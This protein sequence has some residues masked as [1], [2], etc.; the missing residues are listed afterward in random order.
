[1]DLKKTIVL[2][3]LVAAS[4][5][6]ASIAHAHDTAAETESTGPNRTMLRSGVVILGLSYV[7]AFVVAVTNSRSDDDYLFIPVAGPWLDLAHRDCPPGPC[8]HE[9]LNKALLITDGVFQ[10]IGALDSPRPREQW[11]RHRRDIELLR[12]AFIGGRRASV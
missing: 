6:L 9:T 2:P 1:M 10:G 4:V 8:N 11:L 12:Q 5:G 3:A 7:P